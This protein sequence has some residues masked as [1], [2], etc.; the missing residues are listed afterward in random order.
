MAHEKTNRKMI[1]RE[2]HTT[3]TFFWFEMANMA[4]RG[5]NAMVFE[6]MPPAEMPE[7]SF[8]RGK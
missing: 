3:V 4:A 1:K 7:G 2:W 6:V 5:V 8:P